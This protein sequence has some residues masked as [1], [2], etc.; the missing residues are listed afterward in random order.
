MFHSVY[1]RATSPDRAT[2]LTLE[3]K[4]VRAAAKGAN[5]LSVPFPLSSRLIH[6]GKPLPGRRVY[7][8]SPSACFAGKVGKFLPGYWLL[9]YLPP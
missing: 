8:R 9:P 1:I 7:S 3:S 5:S 6:S 4:E 2:R